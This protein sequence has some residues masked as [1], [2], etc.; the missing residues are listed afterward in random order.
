MIPVKILADT[1]NQTC[2]ACPSQW[3]AQTVDGY[4]LY[5]RFRWGCLTVQKSNYPTDD[6]SAAVL[7]AYIYDEQL[8]DGLDGVISWE[9]VCEK[10]GIEEEYK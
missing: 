10:T 1:L 5:I 4:T 7:G 9:E 3:E 8:S 2:N 6:M